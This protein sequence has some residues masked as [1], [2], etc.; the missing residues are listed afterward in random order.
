MMIRYVQAFRARKKLPR[1]EPVG[2]IDV[3]Q[4][5]LSIVKSE[6]GHDFS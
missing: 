2:S 6:T 4:M 5:M 1:I 3:V